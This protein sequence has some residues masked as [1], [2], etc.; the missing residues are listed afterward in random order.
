MAQRLQ[1]G[2]AL[3]IVTHQEHRRTAPGCTI[4]QH[5]NIC[6]LCTADEVLLLQ[7]RKRDSANIGAT[8]VQARPAGTPSA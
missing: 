7:Q 4:T 6:G 8:Q 2:Q 5:S 3:L 1:R